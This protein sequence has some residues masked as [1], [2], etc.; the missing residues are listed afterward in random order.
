M[1]AF[2]LAQVVVYE[3]RDQR[4]ALAPVRE[5]FPSSSDGV[6]IKLAWLDSEDSLVVFRQVR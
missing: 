4:N 5:V 2:T 1:H 6:P 3:V